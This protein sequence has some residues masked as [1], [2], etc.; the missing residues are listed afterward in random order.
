VREKAANALSLYDMSGNVWE[1]CY[2]WY[3]GSSRMER[4]GSWGFVAYG[5]MVGGR[6]G[7]GPGSRDIYDG[8]RLSR[9]AD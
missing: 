4:G 3:A 1:W 6:A 5:L 8:F 9:T 7:Y 2:D